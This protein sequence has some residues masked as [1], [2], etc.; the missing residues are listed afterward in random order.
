MC[1]IFLFLAFQVCVCMHVSLHC[2][3]ASTLIRTPLKST[4][5]ENNLKTFPEPMILIDNIDKQGY[6]H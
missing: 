6:C 1:F 2:I 5:R 4:I 3:H